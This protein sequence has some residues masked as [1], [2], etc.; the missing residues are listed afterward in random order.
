MTVLEDYFKE[1]GS[2]SLL[3]REQEVSLAKRI[4]KGDKLARNTMIEA[5]LRLAISIAKNFRNKGCPFE[6][7]IQESNMGLIRAV[8]RFDWRK[9]FKFSTYAVWWIRQAVQA[10]VA[11]HSG[12]IKLP[13]SARAVM[14]RAYQFT[15]EYSETFGCD[16]TPE[17]VASA[18]G[19]PVDTLISIRKSGAPQISL[20]KPMGKDDSGGRTFAEVVGGVDDTDP[21]EAMDNQVLR[22][23][24]VKALARLSSREEKIIRLRFGM[25][26]HEDDVENFPITKTEYRQ[27]KKRGAK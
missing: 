7:L 22:A 2:H 10:H 3:T 23:T 8:D 12:A 9:G 21:S 26:E 4:E 19:V 14:Y 16:P 6:D 13:T 18:V 24:L 20:D 15:E 5:N 11:S 1:V 27:L 17:E 25:T